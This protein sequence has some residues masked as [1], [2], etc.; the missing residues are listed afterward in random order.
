MI[1]AQV[2]SRIQE[3]VVWFTKVFPR[4][5]ASSVQLKGLCICSHFAVSGRQ[6]V[7]DLLLVDFNET[8][9]VQVLTVLIIDEC[10]SV[11]TT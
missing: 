3:Q 2:D 10:I 7:S 9:P 4:E 1:C 5:P 8:W 6:R 11:S